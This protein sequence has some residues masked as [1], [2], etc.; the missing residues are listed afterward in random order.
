MRGYPRYNFDAFDDY[1]RRL[2]AFDIEVISPADLDRDRGFDPDKD[3]FTHDM[4]IQAMAIDLDEISRCDT[5]VLMP[6]SEKST[7]AKVESAYARYLGI[8]VIGV[9]RFIRDRNLP[10]RDGDVPAVPA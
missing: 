3:D 7:G 6:G 4:Q 1:A 9:E 2:R 5:L 8:P 10:V